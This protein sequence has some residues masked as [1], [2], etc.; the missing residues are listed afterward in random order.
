MTNAFGIGKGSEEEIVVEEEL[1]M[2]GMG[3]DEILEYM[4]KNCR[5]CFLLYWSFFSN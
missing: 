1:D 2:S 4:E 5:C 3:I